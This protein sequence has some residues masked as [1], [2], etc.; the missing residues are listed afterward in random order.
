M[1]VVTTG[2]RAIHRSQRG[3]GSPTS[4][5][6]CGVVICR[7][8][9]D[10]ASRGLV[11]W[12][13]DKAAIKW[14][15]EQMGVPT[16]A[17][18]KSDDRPRSTTVANALKVLRSSALAK[19]FAAVGLQPPPVMDRRGATWETLKSDN[20][21][22]AFVGLAIRRKEW[23]SNKLPP[24]HSDWPKGHMVGMFGSS[25]PGD[26]PLETQVACPLLDGWRTVARSNLAAPA[27]RFGDNR[28][29]DGKDKSWGVGKAEAYSVGRA[30]PLVT[31]PKPDPKPDPTPDP[32]PE[33]D[34]VLLEL[35]ARLTTASNDLRARA[36]VIDETA[37]QLLTL[38][39]GGS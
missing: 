16:T 10:H 37:A 21:D 32:V 28:P 36:T 9:I 31:T 15:R 17:A 30:K 35:A 6:D 7:M 8:A 38:A 22:G 23:L 34:A 20:R 27:A 29:W 33:P 39:K 5:S 2:K 11:T 13:S 14:I 1:T 26:T 19:R 18:T 3:T 12:S 25:A 4:G 24:D